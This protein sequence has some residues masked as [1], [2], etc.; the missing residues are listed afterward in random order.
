MF[1]QSPSGG[2]D[3]HGLVTISQI[4]VDETLIRIPQF[5]LMISGIPGCRWS[6][7]IIYQTKKDE[8]KDIKAN[9]LRS[10]AVCSAPMPR[11][12]LH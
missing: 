9:Q 4:G 1:I 2:G 3:S 11:S 5:F 7:V 8:R 12:P 6:P 10:V